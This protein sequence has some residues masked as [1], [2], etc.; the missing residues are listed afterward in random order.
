MIKS[1]EELELLPDNSTD[2]FKKSIIDRYMDRSTCRKF[3][4]LKTVL[5]S[6]HH[7]ITKKLLQ[8]M[9]ISQPFL[10]NNI[11]KENDCNTA[12]PKKNRSKKVSRSND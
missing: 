9:I 11:E 7:F 12:L 3:A 2:I 4:S 8:I 10:K 6:L 1:K 5:H